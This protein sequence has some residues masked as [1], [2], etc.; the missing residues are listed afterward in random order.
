MGAAHCALGAEDS[1]MG[2]VNTD[3]LEFIPRVLVI[4][5]TGRTGTIVVRK[6]VLR[7]FRVSV[8]VRSL[9]TETLTRLGAYVADA[10]F[11]QSTITKQYNTQNLM[12]DFKPLYMQ[13]GCKGKGA[14]FIFTDKEI[15]EEA[16]LEY[17]NI[18]LNTGELPNLFARD[19]Q[20][21]IY[22]EVA[23]EWSKSDVPAQKENPEPTQDRKSVV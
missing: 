6:L 11:F 12:D 17:I 1:A 3:D 16:F 10:T 9:S 14:V 22:G 18:F 20:D 2:E 7:G 21:I 4:G 19:E 23:I 15:K 8:L 5:A 13:A